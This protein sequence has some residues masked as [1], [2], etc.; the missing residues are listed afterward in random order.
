VT[1]KT[2]FGENLSASLFTTIAAFG[3]LLSETSR[4]SGLTEQFL[5]ICSASIY[6]VFQSEHRTPIASRPIKYNQKLSQ[7]PVQELEADF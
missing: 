4:C 1:D 3:R 5:A 6:R 7:S 2:I